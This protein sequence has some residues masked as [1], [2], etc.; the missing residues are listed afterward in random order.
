MW[1]AEL[2]RIAK[3][4]TKEEAG[5]LFQTLKSLAPKA[6]P[7]ERIGLDG[8]LLDVNFDG[9]DD[10]FTD[11]LFYSDGK[12]YHAT[13]PMWE[14]GSDPKV[15]IW[16]FPPTDKECGIYPMNGHYNITTDGKSYFSGFNCNLSE[17]TKGAQ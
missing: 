2:R 11:Q 4:F 10:Y 16:R 17:L 3:I 7:P 6:F 8:E 14:R 13:E 9:I 1:I 15:G 12:T 5:Q